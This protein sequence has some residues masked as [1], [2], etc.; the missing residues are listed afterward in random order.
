MNSVKHLRFVARLKVWGQNIG[1]LFSWIVVLFILAIPLMP[2]TIIAES[3]KE[4]AVV[5]QLHMFVSIILTG[6]IWSRY[7]YRE[8][9]K[10]IGL[11]PFG[12]S[13]R[14]EL[15]WGLFYGTIAIVLGFLISYSA[16][17]IHIDSVGYPGDF[18]I[19]IFIM[20]LVAIGEEVLTRGYIQRRFM[21]VYG[22]FTALI[23]SSAIFMIM[24]MLNANLTLL[25]Y[26]NLFLAGI[27]L[28]TAYIVT[29]SLWLPIGLHF[30]W[31]FM[32]GPV[33]G[34]AVSGQTTGSVVNQHFVAGSDW[35]SGGAFGF[36]GS[37]PCIII[38]LLLVLVLYRYHRVKNLCSVQN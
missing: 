19:S 13:G 28:G 29:K 36:E 10:S 6:F 35:L 18:L 3:I 16:G 27:L 32:Q 37:V 21:K 4:S 34:F 30:A 8:K 26:I 2:F 9:F 15:L 20:I 24:H 23:L 33:M 14:R 1:F 31:N 25:A 7:I 22:N 38:V 5:G 12:K 17:V 11:T